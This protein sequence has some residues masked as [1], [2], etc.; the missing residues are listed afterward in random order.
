[1]VTDG[2]EITARRALMTSFEE[3]IFAD[4]HKKGSLFFL[5]FDLND[6]NHDKLSDNEI[7]DIT[8]GGL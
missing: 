8:A 7:A 1:M 6:T 3:T 2:N 5:D 4:F